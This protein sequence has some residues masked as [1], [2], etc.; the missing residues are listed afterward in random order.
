MQVFS[1]I[2]GIPKLERKVQERSL[3]ESKGSF[4]SQCN[5]SKKSNLQSELTR[6]LTPRSI[7]GRTDFLDHDELDAM[8][9]YALRKLFDK[10]THFR[11]KKASVEE[12]R[13]QNH[14]RFF[15]RIQ[16]ALMMCDH[17]RS[18]G[19]YDGVQGLSD[20]FRVGL[21]NDDVQDINLRWEQAVLSTSDP[22]AGKILEGVYKS[23]LQDLTQ[24]QTLHYTIKKFFEE[25]NV[26]ITDRM[27]EK[28]HVDQTLRNK[29]FKIQNKMV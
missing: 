12:Q 1:R 11:E 8:M 22:P 19:V 20:L 25:E 13:A 29:Y 17:F 6:F 15:K 14:D 5:A 2:Y 26:I 24:L 7:F 21:R 27:C 3:F 9:A 10:Q 4:Y 28:S 18:I 23:K 16:I